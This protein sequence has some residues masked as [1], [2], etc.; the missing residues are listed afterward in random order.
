MAVC[1][2]ISGI[3]LLLG[4]LSYSPSSGEETD[5]SHEASSFTHD[6]A[7]EH[8]RL[9]MDFFLSDELEVAIDEFREAARQRPGY[10][11]AYHNLGV[12]LAKTGD[13]AGALAA[14][15]QAER[16]DIQKSI[17]AL[18]LVILGFL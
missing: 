1:G 3:T 11:D 6:S 9:G 12:V 4:L 18:S 14:W 10:A 5:A 13:L 17:V 2:A 8:L 7:E 15:S 16:L